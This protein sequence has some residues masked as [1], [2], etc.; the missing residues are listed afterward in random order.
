MITLVV[1]VADKPLQYDFQ[2]FR[3]VV[4][5]QQ[6]PVLPF[7]LAP[8]LWVIAPTPAMRHAIGRQRL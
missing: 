5:L 3:Q 4:V 7:D 2:L 1:V 6:D 8:G